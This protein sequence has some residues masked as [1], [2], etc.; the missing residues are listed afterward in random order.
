MSALTQTSNGKTDDLVALR[1]GLPAVAAS[2]LADNERQ[3]ALALSRA[4]MPKWAGL[5]E[6]GVETRSWCHFSNS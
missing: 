3:T 1:V 4:I 5:P 6:A 2:F